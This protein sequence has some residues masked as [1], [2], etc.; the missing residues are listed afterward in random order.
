MAKI[1][2]DWSD[3]RYSTRP[4][5]NEEAAAHEANGFDVVYLEDGTW[6]AYLRHCDR[7]ATWQVFWRAIANEQSMRRREHELM[8]LEDAARE[9]DRLKDELQRAQ[10]SAKFFEDEW[11]AAIK[12]RWRDLGTDATAD[13]AKTTS[14]DE[15]EA[16]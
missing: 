8:P 16:P 7:D 9:I 4:L 11:S 10:R 12:A 1:W 2:L 13:A 5:T 15:D 6:E 14:E 3:G